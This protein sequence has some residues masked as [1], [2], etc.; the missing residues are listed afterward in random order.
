MGRLSK[1]HKELITKKSFRFLLERKTT[2]E[3]LKAVS[4]ITE[5]LLKSRSSDRRQ[6]FRDQLRNAHEVLCVTSTDFSELREKYNQLNS[7]YEQVLK[8]R[9]EQDNI[10]VAMHQKCMNIESVKRNSALNQDARLRAEMD[11]EKFMKDNEEL[12][13]K[14]KIA[15]KT[16]VKISEELESAK[17]AKKMLQ[18]KL[19]STLKTDRVSDAS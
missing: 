12:R 18:E 9:T 15:M 7:K 8:K 10:H 2:E 6:K 14:L 17:Y 11:C 1:E 5:S 3:R 19:K 4:S 16:E 13:K